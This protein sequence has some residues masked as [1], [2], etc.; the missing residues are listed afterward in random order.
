MSEHNS[1][2]DME[3]A[4]QPVRQGDGAKPDGAGLVRP[5]VSSLEDYT[6]NMLCDIR[7][8]GRGAQIGVAGLL[9]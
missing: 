9:T 8:N 1:S 7:N 5:S 3:Q 6:R 2:H 4:V